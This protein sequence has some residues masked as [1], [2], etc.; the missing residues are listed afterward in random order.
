MPS[1]IAAAGPRRRA[2]TPAHQQVFL[3]LRAR[4]LFGELP[5]GAAVTI[6]GLAEELGAGM[7]PVREA[8][9]RLIAAGALQMQ[10]NRR[11]SVPVLTG[12]ALEE[13]EHLR[14]A[15]EPELAARAARRATG[16]D[17]TGLRRADDALDDALRRGDI[18]GYL[19]QNHAFHARIHECAQA[20]I[21]AEVAD[22]L[23]L[24]F[25]PSMRMICATHGTDGQPDRHKDV[26]GA[27]RVGDAPAAAAAMAADVAQGMALLKATL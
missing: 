3:S 21:L 10:G 8:L 13:I 12:A 7:T 14:R 6:Q 26:I 1:E 19:V 4:I 25:G 9:R 17:V 20:P 11:V 5:P 27:L 22:G 16:E 24:R 18:A 15:V 2:G 23:W